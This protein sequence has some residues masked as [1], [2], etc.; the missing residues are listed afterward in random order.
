MTDRGGVVRTAALI[1]ALVLA[2]CSS[3][4]IYR[5]SSQLCVAQGGAYSSATQQCTFAAGTTVGAQKACQ[6]LGGI[7]LQ[8]LQRCQFDD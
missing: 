1:A 3:K 5:N 8:E 4:P 2:A 6:D 7:Y